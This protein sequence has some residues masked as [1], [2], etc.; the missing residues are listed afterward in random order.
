MTQRAEVTSLVAEAEAVYA[1][2][3]GNPALFGPRA[4]ALVERARLAKDTEALVVALHAQAWAEHEEMHNATAKA[5]L[6]EGLRRASRLGLTTRVGELLVS[7][8]AVLHELGRRSAAQRDVDRASEILP[9]SGQARLLFQQAVLFHSDGAIQPAG[10]LY[11][12]LVDNTR[13]PTEVRAKAANNLAYVETLRGRPDRVLPLLDLADHLA[14]ELGPTWVAFFAQTRAWVTMQAGRLAQSLVL[15]DEARRLYDEAAMP[16]GEHYAEYSDALTDLRLLPEAL[17]A[18]RRSAELLAGEEASLM[19]AE[20]RLRVA[21]LELETGD[22]QGA[23]STAGDVAAVLRRQRRAALVARAVVIEQRARG[24]DADPRTLRR[25]AGVLESEGLVA[26]AVDAHLV[27]GRSA[28][29]AGRTEAATRS[30]RAADRLSRGAPVLVRLKGRLAAS[31]A[32]ELEG[33]APAAVVRTCRAGLDDLARHRS[34]LPSMELRALASGHG[35]ELGQNGLR[36]LLRPRPGTSRGS[37]ARVLGWL[38]RTR[39]AALIAVS[40]EDAGAAEELAELRAQQAELAEQEQATGTRKSNG[41]ARIALQEKSIRRASWTAQSSLSQ[42]AHHV[43]LSELRALLGATVLVEYALLD[44]RLLAVVVSAAP[45]RLVDLGSTAG[46]EADIEGLEFALRR[47]SQPGISQVRA[48]AFR[49]TADAALTRLRERLV[50]PL[51]LD[52]KAPLVVVPVGILQRVPWSPMHDGPVAVAP[53]AAF[54]AHGARPRP[55]H[56]GSVVLVAGP[57]LPGAVDE[58]DRLAGVHAGATALVS[59]SA[60]S[61]A[62]VAAMT[63]S[64]L[65]HLACHG[66][67]RAD[68]PTFSSLL[69]DDGPLTL[70]EITVRGVAPDRVVLAAC[71]S[72]VQVTYAGD[73][74]LG[75]VSALMAR[76]TR[77]VVASTVVVPDVAAVPLMVG[78]H[79]R[80]AAGHTLA[81]SLHHARA[82]A[83]LD[84]PGGYAAWC[85]FT[86]FGA[87]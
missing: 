81:V 22:L 52:P 72:A 64:R 16:A 1:G 10:D 65:A 44:D 76:G 70:H 55:A 42:V 62:V 53:S 2:A 74:A 5:L 38:E 79:E 73:E 27:A 18:A 84:S 29:R 21:R 34:A 13:T 66:T 63:G 49:A 23:R 15:F 31:E 3:V 46:L 41:S 6:D 69:L 59:P 71:E 58:I 9:P 45:V 85:A 78:L 47:L 19:A 67:V 30:L 39:A 82:D 12:R 36:A 86:A 24:D 75:F 40:S 48:A 43:G 50:L 83:D 37:P 80:L 32:G 33:D 25:C 26:D 28:A 14:P 8:V 56:D 51:G 11:R 77:G 20:A 87:A 4:A 35:A 60:D 57:D 17:E 68:S 7:R 54:W 61:A